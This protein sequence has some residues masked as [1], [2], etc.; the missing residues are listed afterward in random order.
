MS[1]LLPD[2]QGPEPA[3]SADAVDQFL[4]LQ[5][6]INDNFNI[7]LD[8]KDLAVI[9]DSDVVNSTCPRCGEQF[10]CMSS[11]TACWCVRLRIELS[12]LNRLLTE[13]KTCLCYTCL[14]AEGAA[15]NGQSSTTRQ[16]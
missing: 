11:Q 13:Y 7:V 3:R 15:P 12:T 2:R 8:M 1:E 10:C 14:L 4:I 5:E 9:R 6:H 16:S